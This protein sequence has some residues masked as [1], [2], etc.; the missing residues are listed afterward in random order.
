MNFDPSGKTSM[1]RKKN[2][3]RR[4]AARTARSPFEVRTLFVLGGFVL[5][6][7]VLLGREWRRKTAVA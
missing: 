7:L 6:M 4:I 2:N 1:W 5:L 3:R